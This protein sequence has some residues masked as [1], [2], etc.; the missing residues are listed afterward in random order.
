V[1]ARSAH[2]SPEAVEGLVTAWRVS[3]AAYARREGYTLGSVFTDVRGLAGAD[4]RVAQRFLR[5][6]VLSMDPPTGGARGGKR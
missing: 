1:T 3:F 5:S 2:A 6:A 4:Q